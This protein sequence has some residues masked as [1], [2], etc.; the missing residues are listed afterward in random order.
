MAIADALRTAGGH[1]RA[2]HAPMVAGDPLRWVRAWHSG[3][4]RSAA[5]SFARRSQAQNGSVACER[6]DAL[7]GAVPTKS[8]TPARIPLEVR[9]SSAERPSYTALSDGRQLMQ[10]PPPPSGRL[11]GSV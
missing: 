5:L 3:G 7:A 8:D 9:I 6:G 10:P 1:R 4:V 2:R 11:P